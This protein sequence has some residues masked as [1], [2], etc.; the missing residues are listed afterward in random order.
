MRLALLT[1]ILGAI[2]GFAARIFIVEHPYCHRE[3]SSEKK[4]V[5]AG[6]IRLASTQPGKPVSYPSIEKMIARLKQQFD[7]AVVVVLAEQSYDDGNRLIRVSVLEV[8]KGPSVLIGKT[9]DSHLEAPMSYLHG[10]GKERVLKFMPM[11]P[12]LDTCA[13]VHFD[14]DILRMNP[15]LTT[16]SLKQV[17]IPDLGE[18][19]G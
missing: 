10:A 9:M 5:P 4:T 15:A 7:E 18:A 6:T 3:F 17:L 8:W 14:G 12:K 16:S 1:L 2:V 11:T 19:K 13:T